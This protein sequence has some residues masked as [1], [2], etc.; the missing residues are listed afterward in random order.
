MFGMRGTGDWA[1]DQR[2][3]SWREMILYLYPNGSAPLTAILSK[4]REEKVS[5]PEYNWWTKILQ[6]Q[7]ADI[8]GIYL[9]AILDSAY[10]SGGVVGDTLYLKMD[11][12]DI[13]HFRVG[14]VVVMRDASDYEVDKNA[15]VTAVVANGANSYAAC[16]LI[17][18][19]STTTQSHDLSDTDTLLIIGN[20]NPEGGTRPDAVSYDPVKWYNL[21]EIFRTPLSIT[22][23]ARETRLRTGD[24]YTEAK[25]ECLELHSIE[26][27]KAFLWGYRYEGTGANGKPE[28]YTMGLIR[29]IQYGSDG[30]ANVGV[31][32]DYSLNSTYSGQTWLQGGEDWLDAELEQIFRYGR[33]TKLAFCGSGAMLGINRLAKTYG[34]IQLTPQSASYGLEVISWITPFGTIKLVL[35]PLFSFEATNRNSMVVFEPEDLRYRYVTDTMF[36]KAPPMEQS[37]VLIDGTDEEYL[38]EAGLEYHHPNGWGYLNGFNTDNSV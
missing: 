1:T 31:T 37:Q 29:S 19:D 34:N 38:T 2:P 10:S 20:A 13:K 33:R 21:T 27:E 12:T 30:T 25:R 23:T 36:R 7:R 16:K 15:K 17:E 22:R 8:D 9:D 18:A 28:R 3:K 26:M 35:H 4:L 6:T 14:H 5:D 24:A 11:G 32:D